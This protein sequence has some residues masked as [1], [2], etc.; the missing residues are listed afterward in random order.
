MK[1]NFLLC[2]TLRRKTP[3]IHVR[4]SRVTTILECLFLSISEHY[5]SL[6]SLFSSAFFIIAAAFC[7]KNSKFRSVSDCI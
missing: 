1:P 7:F 4:I 6:S 2:L 3:E 5:F